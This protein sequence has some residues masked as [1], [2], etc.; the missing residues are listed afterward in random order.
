MAVNLATRTSF[1]INNVAQVAGG[2]I[3]FKA[4]HSTQQFALGYTL[5][6]GN[7]DVFTYG[8]FGAAVNPGLV[9]AQDISESGY[10]SVQANKIVA[11]ASAVNTNDGKIGSKFL[12]ITLA[13]VT[14]NLFAGGTLVTCKD[15][16]VGYTYRIKGNTATGDPASGNFRL[17]LYDAIKIAVDNTTD[18]AIVGNAFGNLEAATTGTDNYAV[19]VTTAVMTSGSYGWVLRRGTVGIQVDGT[20]AIGEMVTI[21]DSEAGQVQVAGGGSTAVVDLIDERIIGQC[22]VAAQASTEHAVFYVSF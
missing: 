21:S 8:H 4:I 14:A 13:S 1:S 20:I 7:G 3:D 2:E 17:E 22:L 12:E 15:T 5:Q 18:I 19:G 9:V 10:A 11:S 6:A 16:G